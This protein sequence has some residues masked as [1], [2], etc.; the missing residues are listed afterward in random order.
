MLLLEAGGTRH[1]PS[2]LWAFPGRMNR[3]WGRPGISARDSLAGDQAKMVPGP[4]APAE[5]PLR[6]SH[7]ATQNPG[8]WFAHLWPRGR[9]S[10]PEA[11]PGRQG[12]FLIGLQASSLTPSRAP[13]QCGRAPGSTGRSLRGAR[14]GPLSSST[15]PSRQS[16]KPPWVPALRCE[17]QQS[18]FHPS[19]PSV[20]CAVGGPRCCPRRWL[21]FTP[22]APSAEKP[23]PTGPSRPTPRASSGAGL[24]SAGPQATRRSR[25]QAAPL[26]LSADP[27]PSARP[28]TTRLQG[29]ACSGSFLCLPCPAQRH[30]PPRSHRGAGGDSG[31]GD[32]PRGLALLNRTAEAEAPGGLLG[33]GWSRTSP[34]VTWPGLWWAW[35]P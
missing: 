31:C 9:G 10:G 33:A 32:P 35:T 17:G 34:Q 11:L 26:Q 6:G 4:P 16:L 25:E 30:K 7:I 5:A 24:H 29:S 22:A 14:P 21:R 8:L 23:F 27:A 15:C 2:C 13:P 19:Q 1:P 3:S 12:G 18:A 20:C 28:Q